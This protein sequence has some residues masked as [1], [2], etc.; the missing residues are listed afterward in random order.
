MSDR[1]RDRAARPLSLLWRF[2]MKRITNWHP[3]I[4][5]VSIGVRNARILISGHDLKDLEAL[6]KQ[7]E[8]RG[9][10]YHPWRN[11]PGSLLSRLQKYEHLAGSYG[12]RGGI[13]TRV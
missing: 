4:S 13:K 1:P 9:V 3:E 5:E 8:A 6:L 11:A 12:V 10:M 7:T 2:L